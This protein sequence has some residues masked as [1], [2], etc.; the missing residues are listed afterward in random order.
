MNNIVGIVLLAVDPHVVAVSFRV[1][2][3]PAR[4]YGL[5]ILYEPLAR[6]DLDDA[7]AVS[8]QKH[9]LHD[10]RDERLP[11]H[12]PVGIDINL[13]GQLVCYASVAVRCV[14]HEVNRHGT[15]QICNPHDRRHDFRVLAEFC[16]PV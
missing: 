11:C 16:V 3:H 10:R 6:S 9:I 4:L 8:R 14:C 13:P 15:N 12:I 1:K 5:Q 2:A 7:V